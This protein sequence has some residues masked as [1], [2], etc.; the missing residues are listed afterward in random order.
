MKNEGKWR[1]EETKRKNPMNKRERWENVEEMQK[2][3]TKKE[4]KKRNVEG[5]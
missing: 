5:L 2:C 4:K 1:M 3:K